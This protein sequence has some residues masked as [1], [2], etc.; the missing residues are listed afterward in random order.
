MYANN[1]AVKASKAAY[2]AAKALYDIAYANVVTVR[3]DQTPSYDEYSRRL[4]AANAAATKAAGIAGQR[5]VDY[6]NAVI[7]SAAALMGSKGGSATSEAKAA[8]SRKNGVKGGRPARMYRVEI[9]GIETAAENLTAKEA[10]IEA[11]RIA[12]QY[13][14]LV[15]ICWLRQSDQQ[16]GYLNRGGDHDIVGHPW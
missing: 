3:N 5:M 11:A 7:K 4:D 10:M 6:D 8:A 1:S 16:H 2:E 15:Y 13:P 14:N 12:P 9:K